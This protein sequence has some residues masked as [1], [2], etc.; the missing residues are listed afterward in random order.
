[1]PLVLT[2]RRDEDFFVDDSRYILVAI[3]SDKH[4]RFRRASDSKLFDVVSGEMTELDD[5]VLVTLG[6]RMTTKAARVAVE[7]P[8]KRLI[9]TGIRYR[10]RHN[11]GG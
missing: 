2:L 5:D 8:R 9:L 4:V 10:D 6:D 11:A 7:A 3:V 1:M